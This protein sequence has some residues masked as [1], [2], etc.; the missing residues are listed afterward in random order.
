MLTGTFGETRLIWMLGVRKNKHELVLS[1]NKII[2]KYAIQNGIS[3]G[4]S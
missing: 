1:E 4:P 3:R 2:G